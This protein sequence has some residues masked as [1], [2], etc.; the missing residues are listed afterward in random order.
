MTISKQVN[1]HYQL[2]KFP[3][4]GGWTYAVIPEIPSDSNKPFG[5]VKVSGSIDDYPLKQVK[6]MPLGNGQLFLPVKAK[7]RKAIGK[8]AGDCVFVYLEIDESPLVIPEEILACFQNEAKN[9]LYVFKS[10]PEGEQ[11]AYLDWIYDC[12][13]EKTK[14]QR[15][16]LMMENLEK[17]LTYSKRKLK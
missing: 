1:G 7:I 9:L 6:L 13:Q 10:F 8:E 14:I 15:I 2:N 3:G 5:W 12:K 17:G 11:K 4:K 16:I